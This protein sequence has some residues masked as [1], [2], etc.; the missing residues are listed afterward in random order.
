MSDAAPFAPRSISLRLYP[1][2]ELRATEIVD[3]LCAQAALAAATGFDGVMTSEH[4]GGFSG[5]LPNPQQA[6]GW[7]LDAMPHGWAAACPL[8]LRLRP[9]ALVA[10]EAAWLAARYPGR[11]G[12]GVAAGALPLDFE[13]L[14]TDMDDLNRRFADGLERLAAWLGGQADDALAADA[15]LALCAEHPVPL[16]SA[17]MSKGAV[18]RAARLG[19]GILFDSLSSPQRCRRLVDEYRAA[20]GD[21]PCILIRRVWLGPPPA[22]RADRQIDVYRAYAPD[23]A[24]RHWTADQMIAADDA[25]GV[26]DGVASV[27]ERAGIDALNLRVHVDGIIAPEARE[28]IAAI[29]TEV[30]PL[31]RAAH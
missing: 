28:Q 3:E 29:G 30:L 2:N 17:A 18:R 21:G 31:V 11:V 16:V 7:C 24:S 26:A 10:E 12:L 23:S 6:A 4:H 22:D 19:V 13:L 20:G 14:D 15:A 8:L 9:P 27:V 1:H 5:Y 25:R